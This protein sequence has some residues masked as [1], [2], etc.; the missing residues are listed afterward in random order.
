MSNIKRILSLVLAVLMLSSSFVVAL[1]DDDE[2][3][4]FVPGTEYEGVDLDGTSEPVEQDV[5]I[6]QGGLSAFSDTTETEVVGI[7]DTLGI[8]TDY[9][10]TGLFKP[11]VMM[12]RAEFLEVVTKLLDMEYTENPSTIGTFY[13][14]PNDSPYAS[15]IYTAT[16]YGIVTGSPTNNFNPDSAITYND[17][18]TM[19]VRA[20]GY[21]DLADSLG[22]YPLGYIQVAQRIKLTSGFSV[23]NPNYVRRIEAARLIA[24]ALD[25][26]MNEVAAISDKGV[27][28]TSGETVLQAVFGAEKS[29]G[30][31]QSTYLD[32]L[33]GKKTDDGIISIDSVSYKGDEL[34]TP[35]IGT[36]VTFW[37]YEE[38]N[39]LIYMC[40]ADSV[41]E[42]IIKAEDVIEYKNGYLSYF[43]KNG[44]RE[45]ENLNSASIFYNGTI[46]TVPFGGEIFEIETGYIK[47]ITN[48]N[49]T[50]NT[51]K[52]EEY[53]NLVIRSVY[54]QDN[55]LQLRFEENLTSCDFDTKDI[56]VD[57]YN[58]QSGAASI[59]QITDKGEEKIVSTPFKQYQVASI[60]APYGKT[61]SE[62]GVSI[63][64]GEGAYVKIVLSAQSISGSVTEISTGSN[65]AKSE[66][67]ID[68]KV[69]TVS[70]RNF[71]GEGL[72]RVSK[73]E[74]ADFLID[75]NGDIA[76]VKN[77]ASAAS[78]DY[79]YGYIIDG[80]FGKTFSEGI[81]EQLKLIDDSGDIL[82]LPCSPSLRINGKKA[83]SNAGAMLAKSAAML[84]EGYT[85]SQLI[86]YK[87]NDAGNEITDIQT[88][89][90]PTGVASGFSEDSHIYRDDVATTYRTETD[91][92]GNVVR[93]SD[94]VGKYFKPDLIF[95][96]PTEE[97]SDEDYYSTRGNPPYGTGGY[98]GEA[99]NLNKL[100]PDA[101]VLYENST[102]EK[103]LVTSGEQCRPVMFDKAVNKLNS[104]GEAVQMLTVVGG[105]GALDF[106]CDTDVYVRLYD[107]S[108][109]SIDDLV[110]G[111]VIYLKGKNDKVTIIEAVY[112]TSGYNEA[113]ESLK[114]TYITPDNLP[115]VGD[116]VAT[117]STSYT[118][119]DF[120][121]CAEAYE[122]RDGSTFTVQ[123][124][125]ADEN[126]RREFVGMGR[127]A[128][129]QWMHGGAIHY[130]R[131][132][133]DPES[134]AV[135]TAS[136]NASDLKYF[137]DYGPG[138]CTK[139][140]M[141]PIHG[142]A[143]QYLFYSIYD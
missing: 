79:E 96:V 12:T 19:V 10:G 24:K 77:Y 90:A 139:I 132:R 100:T 28:T 113:G 46:P 128:H 120:T 107:G 52:I 36:L 67:T 106:E 142:I 108:K 73:L 2:G 105:W 61:R 9:N 135:I 78:S 130:S 34:Y 104:D 138:N 49:S 112:Y 80:S 66:I 141:S 8:M 81:L 22:G 65:S 5:F 1:A 116:S 88:V 20:L 118:N 72:S 51:V 60:Y 64:T 121:Y 55:L 15:M 27:T 94:S 44:R 43:G 140:L 13:D 137:T 133:G 11:N 14:V 109:A 62:S 82:I 31:V 85:L 83:E 102:G 93:K 92:F 134:Y 41:K 129:K 124:G 143:R 115:A 47:L 110:R 86:R 126:G 75:A 76:A 39:S 99:Y 54:V 33:V 26:G 69:Y 32:S 40:N 70:P 125:A 101:F 45:Q 84:R 74:R 123:Y 48:S 89:T 42:T 3:F 71:L 68:D 23:V 56:Y 25:T 17:A 63:P 16:K 103:D 21:K 57:V 37:Y 131:R 35:F 87:L 4:F 114:N 38:D 119:A 127:Y 98:V 111:Q 18:I 6:A 29:E 117:F 95:V 7:L 53:E 122:Y 58:A 136:Q 59:Y 97:N 50:V 91:T 30:L